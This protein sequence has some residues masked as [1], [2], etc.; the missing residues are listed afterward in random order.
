MSVPV[1]HK[2]NN[3]SAT[4]KINGN[5]QRFSTVFNSYFVPVYYWNSV[6]AIPI[7]FASRS[8]IRAAA[9]SWYNTNYN[10][11]KWDFW[12]GKRHL[13]LGS[14]CTGA[15]KSDGSDA[16]A[17]VRDA[18]D[19]RAS[20][21]WPYTVCMYAYLYVCM[22]ARVYVKTHSLVTRKRILNYTFTKI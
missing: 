3:H 13:D 22:H 10:T 7:Y 4:R 20:S 15:I 14:L 8:R 21:P 6:G 1:A 18:P 17:D 12:G 11:K 16:M 9:E 2:F 19:P 5:F